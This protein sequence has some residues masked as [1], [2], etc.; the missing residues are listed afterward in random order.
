MVRTVK[1]V[2]ERDNKAWWLTAGPPSAAGWLETDDIIEFSSY[3]VGV[4]ILQKYV[5]VNVIRAKFKEEFASYRTVYV[6]FLLS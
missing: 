3:A 1:V 6:V 5:V 4:S 2:N